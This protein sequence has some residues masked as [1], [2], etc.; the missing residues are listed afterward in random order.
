MTMNEETRA[1]AL[2]HRDEDV[3]ELALRA[4]PAEGVD[5]AQALDQ[6][7]GWRTARMKL[8]TWAACEAIEYPPRLAMEQCSSEATARYKAGLAA[9]LVADGPM[10]ATLVDLTGGLGVDCSFMAR[11]FDRAVYV[12]R[13]AALCELA[14]RNLAALG[15]EGIEVRQGEAED[16]AGAID[17]AALVY[18]DPARRDAHGA[19]T[20]AIADC[21]PDLAALLPRLLGIAPRVMAKLSP[22]LDWHRAVED[23]GHHVAQVHVVSV[24][25]ECKELLLVLD[26][27]TH[28]RPDLVCA[29]D[30]AVFAVAADGGMAW[31]DGASDDDGADMPRPIGPVGPVGPVEPGA[32]GA[33]RF[34]Y[35]PNAS[36]MKAGCFE[37]VARAF[38]VAPV[39]P[40]S[41]LFVSG[42]PVGSFPG[43]SFAIDAV[44]TMG[45]RELRAALAGLDRANVAVR[46]FPMPAAT[47]KRR[48]GLRDGGDVFLF[49]TTDATGR[50]LVVRAR[51]A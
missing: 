37:E 9:R 2:A 17:A 26:R 39:A 50:H 21:S 44:S 45:K 7:A 14:R 31:T 27:Q 16:M 49:G 33:W 46:N 20:Y 4:R 3:R 22:M 8:P 48:L 41:H 30:G 36:V 24:G 12:E 25:N 15:L 42:A 47:L 11:G 19:R 40:N 35:E 29:N 23:L 1:F 18:L 6:I 43:R 13:Q 28:D 34:L 51:K 10:P 32:P 38:G 5:L